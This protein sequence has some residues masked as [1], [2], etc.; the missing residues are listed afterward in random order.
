MPEAPRDDPRRSQPWLAIVGNF[1]HPAP[2]KK[3]PEMT[4]VA[5]ST[6][7]A[8]STGTNDWLQGSLFVLPRTIAQGQVLC[9][10]GSASWTVDLGVNTDGGGHTGIVLYLRG[11]P[12]SLGACSQRLGS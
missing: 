6:E 3:S 2:Q 11:C 7:V 4:G 1:Q 9:N 8:Q 12:M 10:L 5:H